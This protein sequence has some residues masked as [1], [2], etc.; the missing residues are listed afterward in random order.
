MLVKN[1]ILVLAI[2]WTAVAVQAQRGYEVGGWLGTSYYF[3]DLNNNIN[4]SM[5][6]PAGGILARYNFNNR[7][8]F[9]LSGN[10]G[11]VRADDAR[12]DNAF[13]RSRNL[14]FESDVIDG[15]AAL[16]F[17]FLPY[18]H[19][20]RDEFF[21]PYLFAGLSIYY[22]NPKANFDG[23]M[24]ELRPLGTEGQFRGE[25][26]YTVQSGLAYGTGLKISLSYEWSVNISLGARF[27]FTD[28]LDDVS[29]VYPDYDDLENLR[30]DLAVSLSNRSIP[31][32]GVGEVGE[33]GT[34]RG[35]ANTND[36]YVFLGVGMYY[37][38]GDLR[39][40]EYSR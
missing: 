9:S 34:Q 26:Y 5:P 32:A 28:Y 20:S 21:T 8:C 38:F 14:N 31:I 29:T 27:L 30:G 18:V 7:V 33:P 13:E 2:L 3:G 25:E 1:I 19:G 17:N 40:P 22:F 35:S 4:L 36:H 24:I 37:Y 15:T 12:S 6:G 16:E 10:Y 23:Q 11:R 39:C